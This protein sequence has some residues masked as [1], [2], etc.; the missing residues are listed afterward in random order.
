MSRRRRK[1]AKGLIEGI[2]TLIYLCIVLCAFVIGII[3]KILTFIFRMIGFYRT[4]YKVK[5]GN[6]FFK[7]YFDKGFWGEY[8]LYKK[9]IK[10]FGED[11][12]LTNVYLPS[13]NTDNTEID[14]IGVH[15]GL[16]YCFEMKNYSGTI[17]GKQNDKYWTQVLAFRT[18]NKFLNPIRQNYAHVQALK[19]YLSIREDE[20]IP[21]VIFSNKANLQNVTINNYNLGKM[22]D[23]VILYEDRVGSLT[24]DEIINKLVT[25][26]NVDELTKIEHIEQVN[27]LKEENE[28]F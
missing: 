22:Y 17:Y 24:D 13:V 20:I 27:Q 7:T 4:Q 19:D 2:G 8:L 28:L 26:T 11:K 12:L 15:N 21:I 3:I 10:Q 5:S 25:R 23:G 1:Q 14:V 18:K 6:G 16:V 9:L